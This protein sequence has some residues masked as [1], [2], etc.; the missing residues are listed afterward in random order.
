[1]GLI[2]SSLRRPAALL[3]M[4]KAIKGGLTATSFINKLRGLGLSYRKT[5]MLSDWRSASNVEAKKD[6][7]KYVRKDRMPTSKSMAD[8]EWDLSKEYMYKVNT[9]SRIKPDEPLTERYVNLMSD[10]PMSVA[11][12]EQEVWAS[13]GEW[14]KYAPDRLAKV[15]VKSAFH[16]V[17]SPLD[18]G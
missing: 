16:R 3:R 8:V 2:P 13:W 18:E 6:T 1:M 5:T 17:E 15:Q 7:L 11:G 10:V 14:E 4:P 9:W 12:I